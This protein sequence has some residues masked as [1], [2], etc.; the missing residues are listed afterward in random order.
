MARYIVT[1]HMGEDGYV[2]VCTS[3]HLYALAHCAGVYHV[4]TNSARR[5][6][7]TFRT[8]RDRQTYMRYYA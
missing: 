6:R 1:A 3:K 7:R 4:R 8:L 2:T 5:V